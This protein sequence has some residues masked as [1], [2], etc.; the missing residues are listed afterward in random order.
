M[1]KNFDSVLF[2]FGTLSL[3]RPLGFTLHFS[4]SKLVCCKIKAVLSSLQHPCTVS[5]QSTA[6]LGHT[7]FLTRFLVWQCVGL[8]THSVSSHTPTLV[9]ATVVPSAILAGSNPRPLSHYHS[10]AVTFVLL[11]THTLVFWH[12]LYP[13]GPRA[14]SPFKFTQQSTSNPLVCPVGKK[15]FDIFEWVILFK[16][17]TITVLIGNYIHRVNVIKG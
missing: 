8:Q 5:T 6:T 3:S 16:N 9:T 17:P 2:L 7:V 14:L 15:I 10:F 4:C 11:E 12:C 13:C 1:N